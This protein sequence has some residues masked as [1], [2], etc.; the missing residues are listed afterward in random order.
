MNVRSAGL[1]GN[2]PTVISTFAGCGGSSLGYKLAGFRELLAVEWDNNAVETFRLNFP[3]V[4]VYHGDIAKLTGAECMRLAGVGVG[5][6]DVFD[7][8]PPCQGFSTA[9]KRKFDDPRNS[10]FREY[11]RLLKE[12]QPRVFVME[13]VTG[14]VKGCMKQAYLTIIKTLRDCGYRAR[15]EVLNAMYYNVPQSR[16]RVIIIGVRNDL[17]IEPSH[18]KPQTRPVKI[19]EAFA[20]ISGRGDAPEMSEHYHKSWAKAKPGECV[21]SRQDTEKLDLRKPSKTLTKSEGYGGSYHPTESRPLSTL[22]R[23]RIGSFPDDFKFTD[24]KNAVLRIGN[25][26]PPNLMRAIAEH[27]KK[28]ILKT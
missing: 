25:S 27:V 6:L 11:A 2:A 18:P 13:N 10:L 14:M 12:L 7:G 4:P 15:G 28:E 16:E 17:G 8:S 21:G 19:C 22:E 23:K 3:E 24:W 9:G 1:N 5:E 20:G 26:V